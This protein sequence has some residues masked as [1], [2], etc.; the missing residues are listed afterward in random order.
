MDSSS[1]ALRRAAAQPRQ[2]LAQQLAATVLAGGLLAVALGARQHV[3]RVAAVELTNAGVADLPG[4]LAHRVED[5]NQKLRAA[6][7]A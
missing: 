7:R 4:A 5:T 1:K 6:S 3:R 2:L